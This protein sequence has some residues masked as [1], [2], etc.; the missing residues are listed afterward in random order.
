MSSASIKEYINTVLEFVHNKKT[1]YALVFAVQDDGSALCYHVVETQK[2]SSEYIPITNEDG[3]HTGY[4]IKYAS[5]FILPNGKFKKKILVCP[6]DVIEAAKN[7]YAEL[8]KLSELKA[9]RGQ[10]RQQMQGC[11]VKEWK[12]LRQR[13]KEL[14]NAIED[15]NCVFLQSTPKQGK[16][17]KHD[18]YSNFRKVPNRSGIRTIVQGGK[19]SPK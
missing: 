16:R 11:P 13:C 10:L 15:R 1:H 8:P 3:S 7:K 18:M 17:E 2:I 5:I 4:Q 9:E 19:V 12:K 6:A 14:T